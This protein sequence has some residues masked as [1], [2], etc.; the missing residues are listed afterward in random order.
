MPSNPLEPTSEN[1]P[2]DSAGCAAVDVGGLPLVPPPGLHS[3]SLSAE[4]PTGAKGLGGQAGNGRK[5]KPCIAPFQAG[6]TVTLA[7]IAGPGCVRHI[8]L[9]TPPDCPRHDR[10]L[11]LRCY[12]DEQSQ[13]SVACPLGDFFGLAH[14]RRRAFTSALTAMP[15]ARGLDCYYTMPFRHHARIT[16]ENDSGEDV[17][18]LFYQID[19]TIGDVLPDDTGYFHAQFRRV[20]PTTL[21]QD[22]ILLDGVHGRGRFLGC[23]IGV[24]TLAAH[25]WGEGEFKFYL[26]GDVAY[27]TICGTGV[28]D[29]VGSAWG[30]G[31]HHTPYH[32]CPLYA[33]EHP[34]GPDRDRDALISFYRWHVLDPIYFHQS[35]RVTMQQIG[36]AFVDRARHEIENGQMQLV[37]P[38]QSGQPFAL[39]ERQDDISSAA[40]WYQTLPTTP[41]PPLPDR[42]QRTANLEPRTEEKG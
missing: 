27:P 13:P 8:W 15:E 34:D 41:F 37:T 40:F 19:Y 1:S 36:G 3:R 7:D 28:E 38:L 26:D 5:G 2:S 11:I 25:W 29:Y 24:R 21:G 14:G 10:N 30:L 4:N 32:G 17:P 23:V 33:H 20:N 42:P 12:W 18:L 16:L 6:E 22:Y 39:F 31:I 35:L 9:T